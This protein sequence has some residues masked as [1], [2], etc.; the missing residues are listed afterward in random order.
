MQIRQNVDR[1]P[2]PEEV[3]DKIRAL[4][5]CY[6]LRIFGYLRSVPTFDPTANIQILENRS[7]L[8]NTAHTASMRKHLWLY[9]HSIT[10]K[11]RATQLY[12]ELPFTTVQAGKVQ[13]VSQSC[14]ESL[15][16]LTSSRYEQNDDYEYHQA[17]QNASC[18]R[19]ADSVWLEDAYNNGVQDLTNY[20]HVVNLLRSKIDFYSCSIYIVLF[21]F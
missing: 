6:R 14:I 4:A 16:W 21:L 7:F 17:K 5:M 19:K 2:N 10:T 9:R 3:G 1:D 8:L 13:T 18:C 20:G 12:F 11:S 15:F